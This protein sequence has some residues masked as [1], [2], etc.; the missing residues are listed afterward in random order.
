MA[1]GSTPPLTDMSTTNLPGGNGWP[2]RK[3][4]NL[5][6]TCEPIVYKMRQPRRLTTL[7]A[8]TAC[9]RIA[10]SFLPIQIATSLKNILYRI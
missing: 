2:A 7:C 4:D 10:L 1:L 9:Y 6:A 5:A 3:A 8:S